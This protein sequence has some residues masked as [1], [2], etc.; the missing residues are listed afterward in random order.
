V[1]LRADFLGEPLPQNFIASVGSHP[2]GGERCPYGFGDPCK[3]KLVDEMKLDDLPL[4]RR[5]L[6][7]QSG[8]S[9]QL[10]ADGPRRRG[11]EVFKHISQRSLPAPRECP[12]VLTLDV[13]RDGEKPGTKGRTASEIGTASMEVEERLLKQ[14]GRLV[15]ARAALESAEK[16]RCVAAEDLVERAAVTRHVCGH[17]LVVGMR[18]HV[19]RPKRACERSMFASLYGGASLGMDLSGEKVPA[20][21]FASWPA[22]PN[23]VMSTKI[24]GPLPQLPMRTTT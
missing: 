11:C 3:G 22:Y 18:G 13:D 12:Q 19:G 20:V 6:R 16:R 21:T 7:K 23:W 15:A 4:G 9:F 1:L 2:H 8:N 10:I 24:G 17:E 14:V 5:K